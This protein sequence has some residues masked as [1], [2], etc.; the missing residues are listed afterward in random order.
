MVCGKLYIQKKST[1]NREGRYEYYPQ[2][3]LIQ[4]GRN[5]N[6]LH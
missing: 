6:N 1:L 2:L 3:K 5:K 4:R